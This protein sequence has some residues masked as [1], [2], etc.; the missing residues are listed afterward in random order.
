[1]ATVAC[2]LSPLMEYL[3]YCAGADRL[4]YETSSEATEAARR[5]REHIGDDP[6]EVRASYNVVWL[7]ID[8]SAVG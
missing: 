4:Q 7:K 1:M 5:L 8:A 3:E 2:E 6:I